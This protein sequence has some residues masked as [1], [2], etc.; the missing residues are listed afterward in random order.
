MSRASLLHDVV[1]NAEFERVR[2]LDDGVAFA[3]WARRNDE[4]PRGLRAPGSCDERAIEIPWTLARY[5]SERDVLDVG[6]ALADEFW[7]TGLA[8]AAHGE[9]VGVDL[10]ASEV[11]SYRSVVADVRRLPLEPNS[12]DL[13]FCI[14]TL[15]HVGADSW[16]PYRRG[17]LKALR[18]L[19]RVLR[20]GGRLLLTVPCGAAERHDGFV[21]REVSRWLSLFGAAGFEA[22]ESEVYV[23][24]EDGWHGAEHADGVRYAVEAQRAGAILCVELTVP[25]HGG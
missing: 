3:R 16:L 14:S 2:V 12:F 1:T 22:T 11:P 23:C 15:E 25:G 6:F 7:L 9:I 8:A 20:P 10:L 18:E 4:R 24:D 21:Q 17:A 13:A 19:R 5:R